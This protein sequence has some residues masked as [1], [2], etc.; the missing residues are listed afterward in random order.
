M[1]SFQR[2]PKNLLS[3]LFAAT[4]V[5]LA[6]MGC[7]MVATRAIGE[8]RPSILATTMA[9]RPELPAISSP[10]DLSNVFRSVSKAVK[11]AVVNINVTE[12]VD[13]SKMFKFGNGHPAV[14]GFPDLD[15]GGPA[16]QRGTG[17]GFL[18]SADGYIVTNE[19]VVGKA[20]KIEVKLHNGKTYSAKT[21]GVDKNT[22]VAVI[23]ITDG[24]KFPFVAL[25]DQKREEEI[26]N[27]MEQGDWVIAIG[28]PFG[29]EQTITAGII[30]A[31]GRD[32]P[33]GSQYS[34][35]LQTDASI[36]PGNS[37]GPLVNLRG[38]IIGVNTMIFTESGGNEG[39]G[40]AIPIDLVAKV[41]DKL[42]RTGRVQRGW[43]GV[44]LYPRSLSPEEAQAHGLPTN[45]GALIQDLVSDDAPA[46]KGGLKSG[47][48]VTRFDGRA[49]KSGRDLTSFV[50]DTEVGKDV[51]LTFLR[52][53]K[54]QRTRIRLAERQDDVA[55]ATPA[56]NDKEADSKMG[57]KFKN[58]T[59]EIAEQLKL[60][61]GQKGVVIESVA[62]GS[63][64][65][66]AGLRRG[67]VLLSVNHQPVTSPEEALK[68][69]SSLPSGKVTVLQVARLSNGGRT[70][71]YITVTPN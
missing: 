30:S 13:T 68:L 64:A 59:P 1:N 57:L 52:D 33:Q 61:D 38:E 62:P 2:F 8:S 31:T 41:A 35:Y 70:L 32:L 11:P 63:P 4:L 6:V 28:S 14:P 71:F 44:S 42:I 23:K 27:G 5:F 54:E 49:V 69:I 51:E 19:H 21:I 29:L 25:G 39:I 53:G 12:K 50:A 34:R 18:V 60:R 26:V 43:L 16:I 65:E 46:A 36:N 24:D 48:F 66:E 45:E 20:D 10:A 3:G 56:G 40:F 15:G 9:P 17:S 22:D 7:K 55:Q 37:G 47:D 58:L 67:D